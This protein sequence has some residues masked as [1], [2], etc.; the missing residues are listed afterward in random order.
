MIN[1]INPFIRDPF[2]V[3]LADLEFVLIGLKRDRQADGS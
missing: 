3:L 2:D 1:A